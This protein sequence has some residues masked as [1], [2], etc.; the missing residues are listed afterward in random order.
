MT[1]P[2][3]FFCRSRP[4]DCD[5]IDLVLEEKRV[6]IGYVALRPGKLYQDHDFH[7]A[8][9]DLSDPDQDQEAMDPETEKYRRQISGN[10]RLVRE[11]GSGAIVL[12]PR[13]SRGRVYAGRVLGFE[14]VNN[15]PWAEKYLALRLKQRLPIEPRSWHLADVVQGWRVDRW[16]DIPLPAIPAWIRSSLFGRSTHGRIAPLNELQLDPYKVL[17]QL[18]DHPEKICPPKTVEPREI[19]RRLVSDI[20]PGTFEHLVVALLQLERPAEIWTH[21][22]GSGDGGV[23]GVGADRKGRVVGLLQCKWRY[24]GRELPFEGDAQAGDG[25]TR[26]VATLIHTAGLTAASTAVRRPWSI[27]VAP[28]QGGG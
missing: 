11:I 10:R 17:D 12:V 21:V 24:N 27:T 5:A 6:F 25:I 4:Q 1:N 22:G 8:I 28:C 9:I 18:M 26:F 19:E 3:V 14:L 7:D 2:I 13:P 20:G 16:R 15:P 23:D